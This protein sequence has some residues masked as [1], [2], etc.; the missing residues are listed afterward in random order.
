VYEASHPYTAHSAEWNIFH[1]AKSRS[2]YQTIP[3][4]LWKQEIF[5]FAQ[6]LGAL[7]PVHVA[8]IPLL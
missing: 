2:G 1:E 5:P 4:I 7:N 6:K 3:L 8:T